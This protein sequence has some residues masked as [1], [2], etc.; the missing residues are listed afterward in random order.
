MSEGAGPAGVD[1]MADLQA[2][3]AR[4]GELGPA[5]LADSLQADA[6]RRW[7]A[8]PGVPEEAYL[9]VHPQ[10]CG[11]PDLIAELILGEILLRRGRGDRPDR[12]EYGRRFRE[13]ADALAEHLELETRRIVCSPGMSCSRSDAS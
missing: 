2:E 10:A 3:L 13:V 4:C 1:P 9:D 12:A 8:G 11:H 6:A 5:A 7:R